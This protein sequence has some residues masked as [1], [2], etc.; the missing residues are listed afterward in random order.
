MDGSN[1]LADAKTEKIL[2]VHILGARATDIIAEA[3]IAMKMNATVKDVIDTI[4]AHPTVAEA[5]KE[6]ALAVE[7]RAI[8]FK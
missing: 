4:H 3:A 5:M 1:I 8:H 6:A 7:G 2:G